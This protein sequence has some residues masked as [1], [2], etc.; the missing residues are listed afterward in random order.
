LNNNQEKK[1]DKNKANFNNNQNSNFLT[2]EESILN[3][4]K[5]ILEEENF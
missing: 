3:R 5:G 4:R 1:S 2:K